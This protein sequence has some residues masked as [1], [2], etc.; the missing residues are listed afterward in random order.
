MKRPDWL[1][2]DFSYPRKVGCKSP[3]KLEFYKNI[4]NEGQLTFN[5]VDIP[6]AREILGI[7]QYVVLADIEDTMGKNLH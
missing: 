7:L 2:Q 1:L 4:L 6:R 5:P 3:F